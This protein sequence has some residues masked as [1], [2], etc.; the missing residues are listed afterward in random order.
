VK[1]WVGMFVISAAD[2]IVFVGQETQS[3]EAYKF[4][5]LVVLARRR[6]AVAEAAALLCTMVT[7]QYNLV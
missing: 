4:G 7:A 2:S 3:I 6:L 5:S 1:V